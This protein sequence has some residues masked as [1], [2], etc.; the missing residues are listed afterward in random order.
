MYIYTYILFCSW[1]NIGFCTAD[2]LL[3]SFFGNFCWYLS[4]FNC[5]VLLFCTR[6]QH[7]RAYTVFVNLTGE[8]HVT[9]AC[10]IGSEGRSAA[11]SGLPLCTERFIE[12]IFFSEL[13]PV[14]RPSQKNRFTVIWRYFAHAVSDRRRG[15]GGSSRMALLKARPVWIRD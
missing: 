12:Q 8:M 9:V 6:F 10:V 4:I 7:V 2:N 11:Q 13:I 15:G 5:P 1:Y 3:S 14:I